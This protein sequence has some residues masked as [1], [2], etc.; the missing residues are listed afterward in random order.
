MP[1]K[2][3]TIAHAHLVLGN[4]GIMLSSAEGYLFPE[5]CKSPRQVGGVGTAEIIVFVPDADAHFK[6]VLA[7]RAEILVPIESKPYGGRGYACKDP[8]GY[9]WAF[10]SYDAWAE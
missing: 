2:N 8:E 6:H 1:G 5:M 7:E 10:G 4:G 3:G 9:V